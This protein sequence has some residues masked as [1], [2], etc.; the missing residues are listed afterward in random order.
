MIADIRTAAAIIS[1]FAINTSLGEIDDGYFDILPGR[2]A[3]AIVPGGGSELRSTEIGSFRCLSKCLYLTGCWAVKM[4]AE[5][6]P[7]D[8]KAVN[9]V[10]LTLTQPLSILKE[11]ASSKLA[12]R[13][14]RIIS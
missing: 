13:K 10:Y 9:C 7:S 6:T 14:L 3:Q 8:H 12:I 11:D 5:T 4:A 2:D 1:V